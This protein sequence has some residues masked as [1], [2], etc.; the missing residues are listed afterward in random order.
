MYIATVKSMTAGIKGCDVLRRY[1]ISCEVVSVDAS[2]TKRGCSYGISF[3]AERVD[4]VKRIFG[5]K[6]IDY[7]EIMGD[8]SDVRRRI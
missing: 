7:G 3:H 1:G 5:V 6:G 8:R 2:L 4:E